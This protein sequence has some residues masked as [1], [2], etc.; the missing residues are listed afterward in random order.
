MIK[1]LFVCLGNICRSPMAE[2]V[3]KE[4]VRQKHWQ[5]NF[6]IDSA[7]TSSEEIGNDMHRGTK[8][9]LT[10][11]NIPYTPRAAR[12]LV[13]ADY[14]KFDYLI[15]ME[16]R[17]IRNMQRILGGDPGKKIYKLLDFT[18]NPRDIADPWYTGNFDKT[19]QDVVEGCTGFLD[20]LCRNEKNMID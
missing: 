10:E 15:G 20:F 6:M 7:A 3:L 17:N 11:E 5:G 16:E 18:S 12:K 19:Y 1:V 14:E 13:P 8:K 4:M 2:F 9:K